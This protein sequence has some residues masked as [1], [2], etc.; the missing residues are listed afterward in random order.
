MSWLA[1]PGA[2]FLE[3]RCERHSSQ[4]GLGRQ[5]DGPGTWVL[6]RHF[7][8]QKGRGKCD[9]VEDIDVREGSG[10]LW[11]DVIMSVIVEGQG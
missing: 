6:V 5:T 8:W 9:P 11:S 1:E 7:P 3:M 2:P 10:S 4:N